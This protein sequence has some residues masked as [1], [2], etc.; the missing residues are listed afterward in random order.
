MTQSALID[1]QGLNHYQGAR[2]L[3]QNIKLKIIPSQIQTL[4]GPN[5]AGKSTLLKLMLGLEP[6]QAGSIRH[7]QDLRVGYMPQR[8][9]IDDTLP[10]RVSDFLALTKGAS[11]KDQQQA[12]DKVGANHLSKTPFQ[13][14]SGGETQRVLLARALLR[15]PNL[16]V[17]DEPVQGVDVKGQ[18]EL[19]SLIES[20]KDDMGCAIFMV[21]HDLHYV[22]SSTD[23]VLC[24]N[25]HICCQGSPDSVSVHPSYLELFGRKIPAKLAH[26]THH[27]DHS[28]DH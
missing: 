6:V 23:E 13:T 15:K 18:S 17:L 22:M 25:G 12:L 20:I 5:G 19:Y 28:H 3:L 1:I 9:S 26:Y 16:L 24:L 14:L 4:I 2:H 11:S 7:R 21:S 27:H 10:L 8:V